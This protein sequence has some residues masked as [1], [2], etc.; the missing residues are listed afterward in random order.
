MSFLYHTLSI[1]LN[2]NMLPDV[3]IPLLIARRDDLTLIDL[4][5]ETRK[6][7]S[8]APSWTD[9]FG[10]HTLLGSD[11]KEDVNVTVVS[12]K[13]ERSYILLARTVDDVLH[14]AFL[15]KSRFQNGEP[16][17][18]APFASARPRRLLGSVSGNPQQTTDLHSQILLQLVKDGTSQIERTLRSATTQVSTLLQDQVLQDVDHLLKGQY[19]K[20]QRDAPSE[21][22]LRAILKEVLPDRRSH[23]VGQITRT[24]WSDRTIVLR[25]LSMMFDYVKDED[26][27][28]SVQCL[29][30]SDVPSE[31]QIGFSSP[32]RPLNREHQRFLESEELLPPDSD[33]QILLLRGFT[34]SIRGVCVLDTMDSGRGTQITIALPTEWPGSSQGAPPPR[35]AKKGQAGLLPSSALAAGVPDPSSQTPSPDMRPAVPAKPTQFSALIVEDNALNAKVL[36]RLID[37]WAKS[38]NPPVECVTETASDGAEAVAMH[39]ATPF[40]IIFMDVMLPVMTGVEATKAIRALDLNTTRNVP[41]LSISG[42]TLE[43]HESILFTDSM[44]KPFVTRTVKEVMNRYLR[45]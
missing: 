5:E 7:V 28:L 3:P 31:V 41:I 30:E 16:P 12:K 33:Y 22:N 10:I 27:E 20:L 45:I 42:T 21:I 43:P 11:T 13:T 25:V 23:V 26:C 14:C 9:L 4:N 8:G 15:D 2:L 40:D 1:Q 6:L 19:V 32:R 17:A 18:S 34:K 39:Q 37:Q 38:I 36:K 24:I 35:P 44:P 29:E